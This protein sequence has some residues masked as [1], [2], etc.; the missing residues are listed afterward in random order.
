M[1]RRE[2]LTNTRSSNE[3]EFIYD[4]KLAFRRQS[5]LIKMVLYNQPETHLYKYIAGLLL[6]HHSWHISFH[7]PAIV[8]NT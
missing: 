1:D 6:R 3:I 5:L 4:T 7:I 2:T 8:L